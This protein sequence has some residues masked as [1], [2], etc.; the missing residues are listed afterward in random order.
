MSQILSTLK[1]TA[2]VRSFL[3]ITRLNFTTCNVLA[4]PDLPSSPI[5]QTKETHLHST[6]VDFSGIANSVLSRCPHLLESSNSCASNTNV[7]IKNLLLNVSDVIPDITRKYWRNLVLR[8]EDVLEVLIRFQ[9]ECGEVG[10]RNEKVRALWGVYKW[11]SEQY[12]GFKHVP[13]SKEVMASLLVRVGM[14]RE[15][16]L[17]LLEMES[18]GFL[19]NG[20]VVFGE[21][22]KGYVGVGNLRRV[23]LV[24]DQMRQRGL[25]P[26][27]SSYSGLIDHLVKFK[28]TQLAFRVILDMLGVNVQLSDVDKVRVE[29]IARL[30]CREGRIRESSIFVREIRAYGLHPNGSVLDEI[31]CGYCDNKEFEELFRFLVKMGHVPGVLMGNK[32]VYTICR[33]FG[34]ERADLFRKELEYLGFKPDEKTFGI[35]IGQSCREGKLRSS[36][37]Y[38]TE[39]LSRGL[40]PDT[41]SYNAIISGLFK[42]GMWRHVKDVVDEMASAG[43]APRLSTCRLLL[44]G[45]CKA[46]QFDEAKAVVSEMV[47]LGFIEI[48]VLE[49]RLYK[50]FMLLGFDP[51]AVRLKRDN[52]LKFSNTEFY[53]S[54]GNGLY[55]DTNMNEYVRKLNRILEDYMLPDFNFLI[56]TECANGNLKVALL[57]VDEMICWGQELSSS[58]F[59]VL[60]RELSTSRSLMKMCPG[61]SKKFPKLANLDHETVNLLIQA[62]CKKGLVHDGKIMFNGLLQSGITITDESFSALLIGLCKKGSMKDIHHCLDIARDKNWLPNLVDS[63]ALVECLCHKKMLKET[64]KLLEYML[65]SS[66]LSSSVICQIFVEKLSEAGFS[67][68]AYDL[69]E[70]L[71]QRGYKPDTKAY[72]DVLR[73]LWREKNV[74]VAFKI[75][76][77]MLDEKMVPSWDISVSLIPRLM[78][79]NEI[80][81]ALALRDISLNDS[82][83]SAYSLLSAF[84]EGFCILGKVEEA[85]ELFQDMLSKGLSPQADVYD[86]LIQ[87]HCQHH[88]FRQVQ[89]LLGVMIRKQSSLSISSYR[90]CVRWMCMDGRASWAVSLKNLMLEQDESHNLIVYNI[91]VF[92]LLSTGNTL[93][94]NNILD[95]LI[96][97][98]LLL[99]EVTYNFLVY[100][101]LKHKDVSNSMKYLSTMISKGLAPSNRSLRTVI[102]YLCRAGEVSKALELSREMQ[103]KGWFHDLMV[104]NAIVEGLL[105]RG[106]LQ[107]AEDFLDR[108]VDKGLVPDNVTYDNLIKRFCGYGRLNKA[109]DLINIMLKRGN[110]PDNASYDSVITGLCSVNKLDQALDFHAEMLARNLKPRISTWDILVRKLC[111]EGRTVEAEKLLISMVSLG[112]TPKREMY[113]I[114][115]NKYFSK[116]NL[117]KASDVMQVMQQSGYSPDFDTHWSLISNLSSS[118]SKDDKD[119]RQGFLS[120]LLSGSGFSWRKD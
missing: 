114:V 96:E 89:E 112:E 19:L 93:P 86:M 39:I 43:T 68:T 107:E 27:V 22:I 73:G 45:Y 5:E 88:N 69:L 75:L 98:R 15:V 20:E 62:F 65:V 78:Q 91:L 6:S 81:K 21:L 8:P 56:T 2:K 70:G 12:K 49:D 30:L 79:A 76:G 95:E 3:S 13:R 41:H 82:S 29:S 47:K 16:E 24:F 54:L 105:S 59:S 115:I 103:L 64:L 11:A 104:Q 18:D 32:I 42:A 87:G 116:N 85:S 28:R 4:H 113:T 26:P 25:V 60:V 117:K 108:I 53:D 66:P 99:N 61:L 1:H 80:E 44:A 51:L 110:A 33:V 9:I 101:F 46:K 106:R 94:V 109:V 57:L 38:L 35:L 34:V 14:F 23:V 120:R 37:T 119:N 118:G 36:F 52:D 102:S 74:S 10:F 100:G 17:L 111:Q 71:K 97:K 7:S 48:S 84:I 72:N 31:A 58:V 92:Y 83:V 77:Y 40:K 90:N 50:A 67:S 55:L 63:K